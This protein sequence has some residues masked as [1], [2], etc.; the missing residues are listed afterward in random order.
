LNGIDR[1][2]LS[3]PAAATLIAAMIGAAVTTLALAISPSEQT[4]RVSG[5]HYATS[6]EIGEVEARL[7]ALEASSRQMRT[8]LRGDIKDLRTLLQQLLQQS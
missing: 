8:E 4:G 6:R 1:K 5:G 2:A 7:E 3:W